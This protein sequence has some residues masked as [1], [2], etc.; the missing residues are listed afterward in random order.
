M[1]AGREFRTA[2][3]VRLGIAGGGVLGGFAGY[4]VG[5]IR[6]A[7]G[8]ESLAWPA[9]VGA[10]AGFAVT[11][12]GLTWLARRRREWA[13]VAGSAI[14]ATAVIAAIAWFVWPRG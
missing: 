9:A 10:A 11:A 5:A 12:F 2:V 4:C 3:L 6:R 13:A 8:Q 7:G 14:I 1:R